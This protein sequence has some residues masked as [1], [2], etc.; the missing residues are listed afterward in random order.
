M[1]SAVPTPMLSIVSLPT[2]RAIP[3]HHAWHPSHPIISA[4][5]IPVL[6]TGP[7]PVLGPGLHA[8]CEP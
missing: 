1:L 4:V 7:G 3:L 2:L 6:G 5:P 8:L